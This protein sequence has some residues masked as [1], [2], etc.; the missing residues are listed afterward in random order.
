[1]SGVKAVA[2]GWEHNVAL[3]TNGTVTAWGDNY[4]GQTNVPAGL[5]NVTAISACSFHSLALKVDGTVVG[6]GYNYEN[7]IIAPASLSNVVAIA[8]GFEHSLALKADGTLVA[9]GDNS[10]GQCNVPAGLSNVMAIAAGW[11]HSVALKNDGTVVCWGNDSAG[12]TNVIS[13]LNKVKMIAAA[14]YHTIASVFSPLVQYPVDVTRDMLLIYNNNSTNSI[15]LKDYYLAHR[16]MIAGAS[17]LGIA[18]D[19]N[20]VTLLTNYITQIAAP[21][22]N[23]L[24]NNP[25]KRPQY[26][27]LFYDMP[28]RL[29]ELSR[30]L[31]QRRLRFDNCQSDLDAICELHQW[32]DTS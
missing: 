9:W 5:T 29:S 28:T 12:Q 32:R 15:A 11:W 4:Y 6:W 3:L 25:T 17:V 20:E 10:A 23:W 13:G 26:V 22:L 21:V 30:R 14:G 8:A 7:E 31:R 27:V 19:T 24:T 18:C 1:M 2:A 16:P